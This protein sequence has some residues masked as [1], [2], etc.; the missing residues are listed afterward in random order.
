MAR[1]SVVGDTSIAKPRAAK[2]L[3]AQPTLTSRDTTPQHRLGKTG[4][5]F[6]ERRIEQPDR[7]AEDPDVAPRSG[8]RITGG[9]RGSVGNPL[10]GSIGKVAKLLSPLIADAFS[11]PNN[12]EAAINLVDATETYGN[13]PGNFNPI[14]TTSFTPAPT[15]PVTGAGVMKDGGFIRRRG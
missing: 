14:P 6:A 8:P 13:N 9:K 3:E 4:L 7:T 11:T 12:K 2:P 5:T 10:A 1:T 15:I